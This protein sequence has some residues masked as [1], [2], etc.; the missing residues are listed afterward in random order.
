M[1]V[2]LTGTTGY[3]GS[4]IATQ[5]LNNGHDV[6]GHVRTAD[7]AGRVAQ[8]GIIP[9]LGPLTDPAWLRTVLAG[10][11]GAIHAASPN[12]AGSAALDHAVLDTVLDAFAGTG[13]RYVHTGGSWIHGSGQHLNEHSPFA[14]PEMVAWRP[15]VLERI[16][17]AAGT[18]RATMV[19]P[20]NLYGHGGGLVRLLLNGPVDDGRLVYP[21][22]TQKFAAIHVEDAAALFVRV[23]EHDAPGSYVIASNDQETPMDSLA[24]ALS[25]VRGLQG[26]IRAEAP[27]AALNR[28]GM[29]AEPLLL[30][31]TFNTSAAHA[32]GWAPEGPSLID[33]VLSGSYK[34]SNQRT[35]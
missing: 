24:R 6:L 10:V 32:L 23:L 26:N 5:L 31:A 19:G 18:V 4:A 2:F 33:D 17:D 7:A 21:G 9:Q 27:A 13:Q 1:K 25:Q 3:L 29:L 11:D 14:P 12:D 8:L 22:D 34:R 35:Q 30:D 15:A 16:K 28:L 20:A